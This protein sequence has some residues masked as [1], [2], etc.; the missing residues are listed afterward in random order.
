[1]LAILVVLAGL[2]LVSWWAQRGYQA[3]QPFELM[4]PVSKLRPEDLRFHPVE[5]G[6]LEIE[7]VVAQDQRPYHEHAYVPR[8][9]V[10]YAAR[11][12]P[13]PQPQYTEE[14]LV[15]LL[16]SGKGFTL[17]GP[18]TTGKCRI[19]YEVIR[20]LDGYDVVSP[21]LKD[22]PGDED[23][24]LLLK[25]RKVVLLLDD[26]TNYAGAALDLH[27]LGKS[28]NRNR[29]RWVV[30]STCRDGPQLESV[31]NARKVGLKAF[32]KDIPLKLKLLDL[33]AAE[34]E[35]VARDVGREWTS[36]SSEQYPT[37]GSI[38][39]QNYTR[40]MHE[41]FETSLTPV[42]RDALRALKLLSRAG[43]LPITHR[44]VEAVLEAGRLFDWRGVHLQR[45]CLNGLRDNSFIRLAP[46]QNEVRP[47]P[48]YLTDDVVPYTE[49]KE[50]EQD[51]DALM[52]VLEHVEDT[53]GLFI[54]GYTY[55][56][57]LRT[58]H[59]AIEAYDAALALRPDYP[60]ALNNKAVVLL[61]QERE[62]EA[63]DHLCKSWE[64]RE[65]L[66]DGGAALAELF[67]YLGREPGECR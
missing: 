46:D 51:F 40:Y 66:P 50:P 32:Y 24:G 3:R 41:R 16:R 63:L 44:Q 21:K 33:T 53:T 13:D 17:Q 10:E 56:M 22:G 54:L 36:G 64:R 27:E 48:A 5:R 20:H 14:R 43:I 8:T 38:T 47:K 1:M 60:V 11:G 30:A 6:D 4:K 57:N 65:R 15:E 52:Q 49:G 55:T 34:K 2:L 23:I 39:M 7:E 45:D 28:F 12:K 9:A 18:P 42:Q 58:F 59:K 35:R 62:E 67:A 19:L 29:V 25:A 61:R 37:P 26:L 31:R